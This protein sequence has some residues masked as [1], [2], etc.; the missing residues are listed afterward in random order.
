VGPG[1]PSQAAY[2]GEPLPIASTQ[3]AATKARTRPPSVLLPTES[4]RPRGIHVIRDAGADHLDAA[5]LV[6][7]GPEGFRNLDAG[8]SSCDAAH[9]GHLAV[10]QLDRFDGSIHVEDRVRPDHATL[11]V[12]E[13]EAPMM[14]VRDDAEVA[15][16]ELL[17][18]VEPHVVEPTWRVRP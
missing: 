7:L 1:A 2:A 16:L 8:R 12:D 4:T 10:R 6:V 15:A 18:A 14:H 11:L 5:N 13:R 9:V 3:A 17:L